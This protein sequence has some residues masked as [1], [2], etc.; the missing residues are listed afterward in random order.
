MRLCPSLLFHC[1]AKQMSTGYRYHRM[2]RPQGM[3]HTP[4]AAP[5]PDAV[6]MSRARNQTLRSLSWR[7]I[8]LASMVCLPMQFP[9]ECDEHQKP[10]MLFEHVINSVTSGDARHC[11][12]SGQAEPWSCASSSQTLARRRE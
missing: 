2:N 8:W 9:Q 3:W 1:D 6:N 7:R 5:A 12:N 11:R 4:R 10:T